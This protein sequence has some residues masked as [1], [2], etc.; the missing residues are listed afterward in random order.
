MT[1]RMDEEGF[2]WEDEESISDVV[3]EVPTEKVEEV[4]AA[5]EEPIREVLEETEE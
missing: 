2:V 3:L 1:P 5:I 4:L